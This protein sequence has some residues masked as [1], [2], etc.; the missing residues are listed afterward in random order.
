MPFKFTGDIQTVEFKLGTDN[1]S[2]AEH[3]SLRKLQM[4]HAKAVQ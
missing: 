2:A 4:D 3:A 1:L